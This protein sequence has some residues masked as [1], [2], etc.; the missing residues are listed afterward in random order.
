MVTK[1]NNLDELKN[2][3]RKKVKVG[4]KDHLTGNVYVEDYLYIGKDRTN[5]KHLFVKFSYINRDD[6]NVL[7]DIQETY[8]VDSALEF[9]SERIPYKEWLGDFNIILP[10]NPKYNSYLEKMA[11]VERESGR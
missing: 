1:I 11:K 4:K 5:Q 8:L 7:P 9:L 2:Y 3:V 6:G 10:S